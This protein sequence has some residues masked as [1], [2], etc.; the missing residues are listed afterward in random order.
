M[1]YHMIYLLKIEWV[2]FPLLNYQ[3]V[4]INF[5]HLRFITSGDSPSFNSLLGVHSPFWWNHHF[6]WRNPKCVVVE[7]TISLVKSPFWLVK[8][9]EIPNVSMCLV[10][11]HRTLCSEGS[12]SGSSWPWIGR[13][14]DASIN[15]KLTMKDSDVTM[16][17]RDLTIKDRD[18]ST[19]NRDSS[20]KHSDLTLVNHYKCG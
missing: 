6:H 10:M 20:I 19:K 11:S 8:Y 2:N 7:V 17:N 18:L 1:I 12:S 16:K 4:F 9:G 3:K 15:W 14:C 13:R 5:S